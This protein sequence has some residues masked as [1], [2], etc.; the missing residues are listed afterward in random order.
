VIVDFDLYALL[1]GGDKSNDTQLL[2]G[3]VIYIPP[4]GPQ[5]AVAGSANVPG[6]YELKSS[7]ASTAGDAVALAAGPSN[8]ASNARVRLERVD[9]HRM[10]SVI[11]LTATS[12]WKSTKIQDGDILE[13][14]SIPGRY[15]NGVT[16]RGNVANPGHYAWKEGM[17]VSDLLPDRDALVTRN[18]W[19]KRERLGKPTLTYLPAC[20]TN[21]PR[22]NPATENP[23]DTTQSSPRNEDPND[24]DCAPF[25]ERA[26]QL[27]ENPAGKE[28][29]PS[30]ASNR[31]ADG[32]LDMQDDT[33][34]SSNN[35]AGRSST[36]SAMVA[37]APGQFEAKNDVILSEPDIDWSYAVIERQDKNTLTTSLLPFNLGRLVL[38][39]DNSQNPG[40]QPN[41]VVT[42]FSKA[43]IRVPQSQQTRLVRL[44][45]EF[46]SPGIYSVLPGETL[47]DLVAR[48]G[49][50]TKAAYLYGS[51]FTRESTRRLQQQ[52][53][54]EYIDQIALQTS[55][56]SANAANRSLSPLDAAAAAAAA[57]QS[58][59][60]VNGLRKTKAGGRI[61][62][63]LRPDSQGVNDVPP[64]ALEDG[65]RFTV[66]HTP[67]T[68]SVAGAVY[69][70]N[71]F[72]Y[73]SSRRLRD[74]LQLA[75]GANRDAERSSTYLIRADGSVISRKQISSWKKD[76]FDFLRV[77]P[78]DT[79][80]V[81]LNLN[82][83]TAL[84]NVVDIAQIVGQFGIAAAATSVVF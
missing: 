2:P 9:A 48:A 34:Q 50:F 56:N 6:I 41:D 11:D 12:D 51:E 20:P 53:L 71:T 55:T 58:Q 39:G 64:M 79:I 26:N 62:L 14:D 17:R 38:D 47:R 59:N 15:Q 3:D 66:P 40:L 32:R 10:R 5:I 33:L 21:V 27:A 52:R 25:E 37:K 73:N 30:N 24:E 45:G 69:N 36:A 18:Y 70:P 46:L 63:D 23:E 61:V 22:K 13:L 44:E 84:R 7:V 57:S 42:I 67:S 75:G 76:R 60:I 31:E 8:I 77:Y 68:V 80:I 29:N 78:G 49:G 82:K 1:Q 54:K 83:G 72:L 28:T 16:L 4:V 35:V 19:L 65:D 74:Y 81:P 43:D